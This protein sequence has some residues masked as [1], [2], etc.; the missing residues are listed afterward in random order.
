M[1]PK[2][3]AKLFWLIYPIQYLE[4]SSSCK[5]SEIT[6]WEFFS[7]ESVEGNG[8]NLKECGK[9]YSMRVLDF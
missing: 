7:H 9:N 6:K 5:D 8:N 1:F 3:N 4:K 2:C